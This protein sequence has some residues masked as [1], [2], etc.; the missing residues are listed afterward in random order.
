[1]P[2]HAHPARTPSM[3][4]TAWTRSPR[5]S[6]GLP[7]RDLGITDR[8][9]FERDHKHSLEDREILDKYVTNSF[10]DL[11][12]MLGQQG[13]HVAVAGSAQHA[14]VKRHLVL[15]T[16]RRCSNARSLRSA[17]P[18]LS[19]VSTSSRSSPSCFASPPSVRP[20]AVCS[21]LLLLRGP[22]ADGARG[23]GAQKEPAQLDSALPYSHQLLPATG[24]PN[25]FSL[26]PGTSQ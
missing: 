8:E 19:L 25:I 26:P 24:S 11:A 14:A 9:E 18:T 13:A 10:F 20:E 17:A 1:M 21:P 23:F 5:C 22:S 4:G 7:T 3:R 6:K 2:V 15:S 16:S 12:P